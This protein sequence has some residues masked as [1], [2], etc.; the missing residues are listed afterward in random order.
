MQ[1]GST[2]DEE[3][4]QQQRMIVLKD[5]A[6]KIRAKERMDANNRR[7]ASELLAADCEKA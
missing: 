4:K 7:W 5:M 3:M 2:E 1:E 6:R